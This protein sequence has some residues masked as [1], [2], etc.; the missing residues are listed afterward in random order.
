MGELGA[1]VGELA[2]GTS[3][4]HP[5]TTE[6]PTTFIEILKYEVDVCRDEILRLRKE[7]AYVERERD[8]LRFRYE[9]LCK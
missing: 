7:L 5:S 8:E 3:G 1:R 9:G 6:D 4:W 2:T